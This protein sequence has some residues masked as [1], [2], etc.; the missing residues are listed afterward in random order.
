MLMIDLLLSSSQK[1]SYLT[2]DIKKAPILEEEEEYILKLKKQTKNYVPKFRMLESHYLREQINQYENS[3]L[4]INT[5]YWWKEFRDSKA[6]YW[7][8]VKDTKEKFECFKVV[9]FPV[10]V[11][12]KIVKIFSR[13]RIPPGKV[14][15]LCVVPLPHFLTYSNFPEDRRVSRSTEN[16]QEDSNVIPYKPE[17]AF[18]RIA[19]N[20]ND[21]SI[22]RQ[23]DTV[24]DVILEYKWSTFIRK[25]F[26]G[27]CLIYIAY[28]ISYSLGVSFSRKVFKYEPGAALSSA[29]QIV[30]IVIMAVSVFI[31]ILQELNQVYQSYDKIL[32]LKSLYNWI[33]WATYLLSIASLTLLLTG[34]TNFE[35]VNTFTT[36]LL[37]IHGIL[38]ARIISWVVYIINNSPCIRVKTNQVFI[39]YCCRDNYSINQSCKRNSSNYVPDYLCFYKRPYHAVVL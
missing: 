8:A 4:R 5:S 30:N 16:S 20:Q 24:L 36:L 32:Y 9:C 10:S 12:Q 34:G 18:L 26:I 1:L 19:A 33:D 39:G 15:V 11:V 7:N 37:W 25:R 6:K 31:A 38:K 28:Y 21:N 2:V 23:G 29:G 22:F 13:R 27:A 3:V 35:Q 17:S 14:A